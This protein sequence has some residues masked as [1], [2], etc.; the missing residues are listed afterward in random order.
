AEQDYGEL[1]GYD[2][3][4]KKDIES[5]IMLFNS[6]V[7]GAHVFHPDEGLY[8]IST[9]IVQG[10]TAKYTVNGKHAFTGCVG[11]QYTKSEFKAFTDLQQS[12]KTTDSQRYNA[13]D[14]S[15][16]IAIGDVYNIG[17]GRKIIVENDWMHG[18][19]FSDNNGEINE[20][21]KYLDAL[22]ALMRVADGLAPS[23]IITE[24]VTSYALDFLHDQGVDTSKEFVINGTKLHVVNGRI[25]EVGN[26]TGVPNHVY[27]QALAR[28][29]QWLYE[30]LSDRKKH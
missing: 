15:I 17:K 27:E 13:E 11:M 8:E 10:D 24:D 29:E 18:I 22:N 25:R 20:F 23:S 9:E 7:Q 3:K 2:M 5:M 1:N 19:G 21:N 4:M 16:N 14:N 28:Y 6:G 12:Y 30:P 26:K